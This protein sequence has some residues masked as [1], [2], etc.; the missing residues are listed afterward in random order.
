MQT[1]QFRYNDEPFGHHYSYFV[2]YR[3][4]AGDGIFITF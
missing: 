1:L 2:S 4:D 3:I